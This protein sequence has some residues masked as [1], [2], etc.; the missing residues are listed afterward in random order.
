[1]PEPIGRGREF[2]R[3]E[4]LVLGPIEVQ[5]RF[6]Q[7]CICRFPRQNAFEDVGGND[8][9]QEIVQHDPLVVK[10]HFSLNFRER[11]IRTG[12]GEFIMKAVEK[13]LKLGNYDVFIIA[14]I[15]NDRSLR[16]GRLLIDLAAWQVLRPRDLPLLR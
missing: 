15:A 10:A 2:Q 3:H 11:C 8:G 9:W 14:W 5:S 6:E 16:I 1:M 12:G 7:R 4:S 13:S